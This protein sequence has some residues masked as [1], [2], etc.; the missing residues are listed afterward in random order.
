VELVLETLS[1]ENIREVLAV[2]IG[3][4]SDHVEILYDIDILYQEKAKS[5]GMKLRRTTSLNLSE[6]FIEVL[7]AI[8]EE[9]LKGVK[10]PRGQGV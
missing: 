3:F 1:K 7:S 8:V 9:H 6:K 10:G 4:V 2:P 5:L